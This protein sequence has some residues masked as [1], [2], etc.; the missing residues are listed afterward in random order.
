MLDY[1]SEFPGPDED[2]ARKT[3]QSKFYK[4]NVDNEYKFFLSNIKH[5]GETQ[6]KLINE[7]FESSD[8]IKDGRIKFSFSGWMI[9]GIPDIMHYLKIGIENY[10]DKMKTRMT[11]LFKSLVYLN[12]IYSDTVEKMYSPDS[13][14]VTNVIKSHY[15]QTN[16]SRNNNIL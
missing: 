14:Y 6:T 4:T 13:N 12:M 2:H 7:A 3:I 10:Y 15:N 1:Y 11:G 9:F 16:E 5:G 8:I